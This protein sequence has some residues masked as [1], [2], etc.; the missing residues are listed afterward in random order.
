V[1]FAGRIFASSNGGIQLSST[2]GATFKAL[3][4]TPHDF[5]A[6]TCDVNGTAANNAWFAGAGGKVF[7]YNGTTFAEQTTPGSTNLNGIF[8]NDTS[9]VYAVGDGG[10][11]IRFGG[12]TWADQTGS[13][14]TTQNLY[15]VSGIT[16]NVLVVG[17][18][19]TIL[20]ST[21]SG[22]TWTAETS[23][24]DTKFNAVSMVGNLGEAFAV[25]DGGRIIH[26]TAANTWVEQSTGV[27]QNLKAVYASSST[28]VVAAGDEGAMLVYNGSTWATV[29]NPAQTAFSISGLLVPTTIN[30]LAVGTDGTDGILL[31]LGTSGWAQLL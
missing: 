28:F 27:G 25:G 26:R 1:T 6:V 16:G 9:D 12:T 8:A 31:K 24:I 2:D 29:T 7:L 14:G 11:I 5:S 4:G 19:K 13:S 23:P 18:A 3:D 22:A 20:V 30:G 17:A 10:T 21:N 15:G